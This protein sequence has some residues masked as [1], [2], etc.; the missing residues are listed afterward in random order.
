MTTMFLRE[1]TLEKW[2]IKT[3][4]FC[5]L[6]ISFNHGCRL[7]EGDFEEFGDHLQNLWLDNNRWL[8][9]T[10]FCI[11]SCVYIHMWERNIFLLLQDF[12]NSNTNIW[13]SHKVRSWNETEFG[14]SVF[15]LKFLKLYFQFGVVETEQQQAP[16]SPVWTC[17]ADSW[18][19]QAYRYSW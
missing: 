13:R 17:W 8:F 19:S 16:N 6:N 5:L 15:V 3:L 11:K 14:T 2:G 7:E 12:R 4:I 18:H 9:F 10:C 1:W